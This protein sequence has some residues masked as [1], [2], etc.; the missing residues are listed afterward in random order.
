MRFLV[1]LR[2][3][4]KKALCFLKPKDSIALNKLTPEIHE[5]DNAIYV[6][7]I[8]SGIE[9]PDVKN[10]ALLGGY[11]TGKSSILLQLKQKYKK[12]IKTISFLTIKECGD[13]DFEQDNKI[14]QSSSETKTIE[15]QI[16][17]EIFK[18][19]YYGEKPSTISQTK[20]IRIGKSWSWIKC[21][22][23][24]AVLVAIAV[25]FGI[26]TNAI[27]MQS[28]DNL[29]S[30]NKILI[31]AAWAIVVI[32]IVLVL[33]YL[34]L[35]LYRHP[36]GKIS[37]FDLSADLLDNKADFEQMVDEII[38]IFKKSKYNV[39][40]FEDLDRFKD[41]E[42]IEELRQLNY[43]IN[44]SD[45]IKDKKKIT[46]IYPI[47]D[48]LIDD[49]NKLVKVFDLVIPVIPFMSDSNKGS[50]IIDE[51]AEVG[52]D[53][54][55]E[56]AVIN[57]LS[58][59]IIDMREL[60][61]VK[62]AYQIYLNITIK[63]LSTE[64]SRKEL[65]GLAMMRA[66]YPKEIAPDNDDSRLNAFFIQAS[67]KWSERQKEI[68]DNLMLAEKIEKSEYT[69]FD[70][71]NAEFETKNNHKNKVAAT[72][73]WKNSHYES[74]Y[75]GL[76]WQDVLLEIEKGQK[77]VAQFNDQSIEI[78]N[79]KIK[80][81]DSPPLND[82]ID[83]FL[84][85]IKNDT[86]HYQNELAAHNS[87]GKFAYIDKVDAKNEYE[88]RFK[89]FVA[90]LIKA[91]MLSE[92][93]VLYVSRMKY[94]D[95]SKSVLTY[96]K[97]FFRY[98]NILHDQPDLTAKDIKCILDELTESDYG[99]QALYNF[100]VVDYLCNNNQEKLELLVRKAS[101]NLDN[102][103]DFLDAYCIANKNHIADYFGDTID[104]NL[105]DKG[106][107]FAN[108]I[109][110]IGE[111]VLV[112]IAVASRIYPKQ[113]FVHILKN[114][115][116]N[117]GVDKETYFNAALMGYDVNNVFMFG[118]ED[119]LL[120]FQSYFSTAIANKLD[121]KICSIMANNGYAVPN[122][123]I[124]QDQEAIEYL[125]QAK[126]FNLT[127]SNIANFSN[128]QLIRLLS[129]K[130]LSDQE[131]IIIANE[132]VYE[133]SVAALLLDQIQDI[134]E[135][136]SV[137]N[138]LCNRLIRNPKECSYNRI[139]KI[140]KNTD[141]FLI[142]KLAL[143]ARLADDELITVLNNTSDDFSTIKDERPRTVHKRQ[144]VRE[145]KTLAKRLKNIGIISSWE[146]EDDIIKMRISKNASFIIEGVN[147]KQ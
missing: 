33:K 118:E 77:L 26:V 11:G 138:A 38:Y 68:R 24:T 61:Y 56:K 36:I 64:P 34:S 133:S 123:E 30:G 85:N 99:N 91:N 6:K 81:S 140:A 23:I 15:N 137:Y 104:G 65:L 21:I 8:I 28:F 13:N 48:E 50:Y 145:Y 3:I 131:L 39:V 22:S 59:W 113:T 125:V 114:A 102:F 1:L 71:I 69:L 76:K 46:F 29:F 54:S 67:E 126:N 52:L 18:Q 90:D 93:Y 79:Q 57:T 94:S 132:L 128:E 73:I 129:D 84:D 49:V 82:V 101:N 121:I 136:R 35:F 92:N 14:K 116:L 72:L 58:K 27:N 45:I 37:A 62:E 95:Q 74:P 66:Y 42:I 117:R 142:I 88:E 119:M 75:K 127:A 100:Q 32:S 55:K 9:D 83:G 115:K 5:Q 78:N 120:Y 108:G 25:C 139:I 19:L 105:L 53:L 17:T 4:K 109:E 135:N 112:F 70:A 41:V 2:E 107:Y 141:E 12:D 97:V 10:I 122:I 16:Q 44:E 51:F 89:N 31:M 80:S 130:K 43:L 143:K 98:E 124:I 134:T 111:P 146:E 60:R 20:Y 106:V 63:N 110:N 96:K 47:R 144:N 147:K 86:E 7:K 87:T 40:V 103:L